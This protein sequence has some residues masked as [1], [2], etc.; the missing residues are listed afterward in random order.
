M[1]ML[2]LGTGL[3]V[4]GGA[5]D[6]VFRLRMH[7]IGQKWAILQGGAFDYTRYHKVRKEHGW[8][9]W[10]VYLMW[11]AFASGVSLLIAGCFVYL[12]ASPTHIR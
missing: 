8:A 6:S 5:L 1:V 3:V 2:I 10:P 9:A 7:R 11:V 12:G 4:F